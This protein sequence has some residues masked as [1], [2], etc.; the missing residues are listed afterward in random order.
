M[1]V[2]TKRD[3]TDCGAP[4][5][6]TWCKPCGYKNRIRPK[7]LQYS[8][9]AER[10]MGRELKAHEVVHHINGNKLDNREADLQVVTKQAHDQFHMGKA[11]KGVIIV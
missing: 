4:T 6:K 9:V 5:F 10:M 2:R 1:R 3:C 11:R 7:G 8:I